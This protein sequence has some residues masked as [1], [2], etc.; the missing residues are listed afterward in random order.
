MPKIS[1]LS[2]LLRQSYLKIHYGAGRLIKYV[3]IIKSYFMTI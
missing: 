2:K 3:S 1:E